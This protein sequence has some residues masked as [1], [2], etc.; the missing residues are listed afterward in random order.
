[1]LLRSRGTRGAPGL[2]R[3]GGRR[4]RAR[5]PAGSH[6]D[7]PVASDLSGWEATRQIRAETATAADPDSRRDGA[8][9]AGRPRTRPGR[10]MRRLHSQADQR[11]DLRHPRRL[12][13]GHSPL[14]DGAKPPVR[15]TCAT[16]ARD[17]SCSSTTRPTSAAAPG[18][19]R[20]RTATR[21]LRRRAPRRRSRS[22]RRT[23][24]SISASST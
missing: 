6:P 22:S 7:G 5:A 8:R 4:G 21:S 23:A 18:G 17:E 9:D 20:R 16:A 19:S 13:P 24:G 14:G 15:R 12:V 10:R 3:P 1:M 2:G 11:R